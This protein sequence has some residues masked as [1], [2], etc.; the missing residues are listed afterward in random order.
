ML[1]RYRCGILELIVHEKY[2]FFHYLK[3]YIKLKIEVSKV[4]KI[5]VSEVVKEPTS[6]NREKGRAT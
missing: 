2:R 6:Q 1:A 3:G 4:L 5:Q